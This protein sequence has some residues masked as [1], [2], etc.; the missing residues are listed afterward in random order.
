M[1]RA[2]PVWFTLL[3][4]PFGPLCLAGDEHGLRR[5]D[6]QQGQRQV[7]C[8]PAWQENA[9]ALARA[10]EQF[11]EYFAGQRHTFSL[12]L[13][14]LGTPFQQRVWQ[15]LQHIPFG[16]TWTY[17]QMARYLG[18]PQAARA[19]GQANGRNP[20]AIVIP[21]HRLIGSDGRLRGYASGVAF[22][23][24]LLQH[25]GMHRC[26]TVGTARALTPVPGAATV[27]P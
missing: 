13:A 14:P 19:V 25:E 27:C 4:S 9:A 22:K 3:D 26:K 24:Q 18:I 5:A 21:C 8:E 1:P 15:A 7:W 12:A 10:R 23:Q 2:T 11:H 17:R 20:L 6:F 16:T